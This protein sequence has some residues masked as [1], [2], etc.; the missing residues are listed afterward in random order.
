M[1]NAATTN[2]AK[3]E[4]GNQ[5]ARQRKP[6]KFETP[7]NHEIIHRD[8]PEIKTYS[9]GVCEFELPQLCHHHSLAWGA[10]AALPST[11]IMLIDFMWL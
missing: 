1:E 6:S 9:E 2:G 7:S 11:L 4:Q 3:W 8:S 5:N 10:V